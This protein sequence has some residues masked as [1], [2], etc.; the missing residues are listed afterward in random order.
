MTSSWP[1]WSVW[2]AAPVTVLATVALITERRRWHWLVS[3]D[4][5]ATTNRL[6]S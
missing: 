6:T 1:A 3:A 2:A 5:L 4:R